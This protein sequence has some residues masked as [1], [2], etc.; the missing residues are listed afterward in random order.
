[1]KS[2]RAG[3]AGSRLHKI[4]TGG[5]ED[6]RQHSENVEK[7]KSGYQYGASIIAKENIKLLKYTASQ[8]LA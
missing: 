3:S 7:I 1:M 4:A 6:E 8:K 2:G 5:H